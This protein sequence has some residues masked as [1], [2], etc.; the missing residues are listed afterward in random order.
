[1]DELSFAKQTERMIKAN[2]D[3]VVLGENRAKLYDQIKDQLVMTL[4][5]CSEED[6]EMLLAEEC[7]PQYLSDILYDFIDAIKS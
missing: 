3:G 1:M 5:G 2:N 4:N 7:V 6:I